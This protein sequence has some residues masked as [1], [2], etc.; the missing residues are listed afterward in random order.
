MLK[1]FVC[2]YGRIPVEDC[3][4][5]CPGGDRCLSLPT[6]IQI[7]WQRPWEGKPSI[8]QLLNGTRMAYLEI[9]KDYAVKPDDMAFALLGTRHHF[10]LDKIAKKIDALSEEKLEDEETKGT[11]DLLVP[12]ETTDEEKYLLYD[13]KTSGSFKVAKAL[14]LTAIKVPSPTEVYEKSGSWGKAGTPKMLTIWDQNPAHVDMWDWELQLNAYRLKVEK[15]GFSI[16]KM[17][18]QVTARDGGTFIAENRGVMKNIYL[19]PVKRLDDEKVGAYFVTKA[20]NL[21]NALNRKELPPP[22]NDQENWEGNRCKSYCN[23]W[24][25]CDLGTKLHKEK[26]VI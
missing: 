20:S 14:G 26:E 11:L 25:W 1:F 2:S 18:I 6:L 22:C 3:L 23:V 24:E 4:R 9:I 5:K 16:S 19:I 17:F 13:Y 21:L 7:S 12:D 10:R 8:T 15:I